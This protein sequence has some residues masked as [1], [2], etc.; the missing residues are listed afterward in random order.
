MA[1][2]KHVKI[3]YCLYALNPLVSI[4]ESGF[5]SVWNIELLWPGSS[6]CDKSAAK[7]GGNASSLFEIPTMHPQSRITSPA[8][9]MKGAVLPWK[10]H[11]ATMVEPEKWSNVFY[12]TRDGDVLQCRGENSIWYGRNEYTQIYKQRAQKSINT[13]RCF[14]R[15]LLHINR[16]DSYCTL[17]RRASSTAGLSLQAL[18]VWHMSICKSCYSNLY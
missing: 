7:L 16:M 13:W 5:S 15:K 4:Q 6:V 14:F 10:T 17:L 3:D 1:S 12:T 8:C 11:R 9:H 18:I 2:V